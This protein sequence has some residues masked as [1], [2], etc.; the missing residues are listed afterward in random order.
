MADDTASLTKSLTIRMSE[1]DMQRVEDLKD[2]LQEKKGKTVRVS[3]RTVILEALDALE[4]RRSDLERP[5]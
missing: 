3:Q 1:E 5:R 4:K 2:W